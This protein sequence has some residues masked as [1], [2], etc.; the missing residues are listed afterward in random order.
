[1]YTIEYILKQLAND[2]QTEKLRTLYKADYIKS[3]PKNYR[4]EYS[5]AIIKDLN[6]YNIEKLFKDIKKITRSEPYN[7]KHEKLS[8]EKILSIPFQRSK[9]KLTAKSLKGCIFKSTIGEIIDYETPI[10][11]PGGKNNKGVG[12][13]DLLAYNDNDKYLSLIEFKYKN[14]QE[15]LLRAILEICTYYYQIDRDR[16]KIDFG[17]ENIGEIHKVVLVYKGSEQ[18]KDYLN[19]ETDFKTL[20]QKLDVEIYLFDD[21]N[22]EV[23]EIP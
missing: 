6:K 13:V 20:I 7:M 1:M 16:L 18:H 12:K 19:S 9:E 5:D 11:D 10:K 2:I 21:I 23:I 8:L 17:K 14:N 22:K 4:K 15:P 3:M